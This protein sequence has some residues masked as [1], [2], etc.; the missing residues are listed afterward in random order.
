MRRAFV[1]STLAL[2]AC[3]AADEA[4]PVAQDPA[5]AQ[6]AAPDGGDRQLLW[7]DTHVHTS[8]SVDAFMSGA[9]NADID[10]AYRYARGLPVI[11]PRTGARV[12][13]DRPLD[14]IV[15]AD[16]AENLGISMRMVRGDEG[17]LGLP[18]GRKLRAL[19]DEKGGRAVT[20]ALMGG[21]GLSPEEFARQNDEAHLPHV[22][23]AGWEA[24]VDA[25]ERFNEPGVF[26]AMIG[27]E[28]TSTP[29]VRNLHRV[30]FTDADGDVAR[31]FVP[32][33][34][35]MSDKPEDLWSFFEETRARTG[36]DFVAMPH[37]SNLSDGRMFR[38]TDSAGNAFTA[39][40][41]SRRA[42]WEPVTEITQYKGTSETHPALAPRD[43]FA[44]FELRNMLLTGVPT[45]A[46]AGSYV[47]SALLAGLAEER[48]IGANP[49]RLGII[50]STDSHTGFVSV[51]EEGFLGKLGEDQL[52]RERLGPDKAQIIFPAAEM[53]ASG[54]AGVWADRNDRRSIFDA[55][56]RREVYG[57]SGPRIMLRLFAGYGFSP[58]D[59]KARDFPG[60]GYRGGVP[61]G[62]QL[63]P[64][65]GGAPVFV[66]RAVKDPET[67]GL[68]RV[69]VIKGWV[70][71]GG[72]LHEKIFEVAWAGNRA[73]RADGS[74]PPLASRVDVAR[75]RNDLAAG[76]AELTAFW[77][78]PEFDRASHAF[79]YVR[80]LQAPTLRHH[81]YDALALGI[82]PLTLDLP[83]TIQERAWS[84]PVWYRP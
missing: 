9:A 15:V 82:D 19:Y 75:A 37:N 42:E 14:F 70:D 29:D 20:S 4:P 16:H 35:W 41:A 23:Q 67:A 13:I 76:A 65:R 62:G 47:R 2:A 54:L 24:Q 46:Q 17:V 55:F 38:L 12:R 49:F 63:A 77:R 18:F 81:V 66:I 21:Q 33:A 53:S 40:Y 57:T 6:A 7:G 68:D 31:R 1:L 71:A 28:W 56:R 30:V 11:N 34:N 51:L 45:E 44:G 58:G 3:S 5:V 69:Q 83:A 84:S 74:L 50:G 73:R 32:F 8:N 59:E 10:T 61:M 80:V 36:A 26:T 27:W 72:E 64:A 79:Y 60:L 52:P 25:A 39:A 43:E 22:L 48:R 78:D